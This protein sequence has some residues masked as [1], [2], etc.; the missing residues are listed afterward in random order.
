E[1]FGDLAEKAQEGAASRRGRF[2]GARRPAARSEYRG[3]ELGAGV[4]SLAA[5]TGV[6][7]HFLDATCN[8]P[9]VLP[10]H[11]QGVLLM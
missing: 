4:P 10:D 7:A 6:A 9:F 1:R 2:S 5:A 3:E 11:V 8:H